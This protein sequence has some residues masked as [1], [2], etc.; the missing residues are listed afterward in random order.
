METAYRRTRWQPPPWPEEGWFLPSGVAI[1][2]VPGLV[3]LVVLTPSLIKSLPNLLFSL[4]CISAPFFS[5]LGHLELKR[6]NYCVIHELD[7]LLS[8]YIYTRI[9]DCQDFCRFDFVMRVKVSLGSSL[10]KYG[11]WLN[12]KFL[13]N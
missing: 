4:S 6:G 12:A 13:D 5:F 3:R 10:F 8:L 9:D 11:F 2:P 1:S 7:S